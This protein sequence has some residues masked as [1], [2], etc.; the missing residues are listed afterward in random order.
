LN[1]PTASFDR[2]KSGEWFILRSENSSF[3][4]FPFGAAGDYDGDGKTDAVVFR[5]SSKT[6]LAQKLTSGTLIQTFGQPGDTAVPNA[7]VP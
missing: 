1:L 7:F 2:K 3:Y 4:S 5:P 6:W